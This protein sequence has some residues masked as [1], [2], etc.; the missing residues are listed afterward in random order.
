MKYLFLIILSLNAFANEVL[1]REC[2][3]AAQRFGNGEGDDYISK[4]CFDWVKASKNEITSFSIPEKIEVMGHENIIFISEF[5]D[6]KYLTHIIAG[7]STGLSKVRALTLNLEARELYVLQASDLLVFSI[8]ITGNV[9]PMR[10]WTSPDILKAH[11]IGYSTASDELIL[12]SS[13][14]QKVLP[15]LIK[16]K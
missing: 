6:G 11:S 9:G 3:Q 15:R 12:H 8:D 4:D 5:K 2:T 1:V 7:V 10:K 16:N 13:T 14:L